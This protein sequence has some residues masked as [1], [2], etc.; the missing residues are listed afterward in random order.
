MKTLEVIFIQNHPAYAHEA[1]DRA[2]LEESAAKRAIDMGI[3]VASKKE[4]ETATNPALSSRPAS[5]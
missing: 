5:K 2:T 4:P 3:A 1:G